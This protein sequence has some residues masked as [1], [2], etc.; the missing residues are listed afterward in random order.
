ME[1]IAAKEIAE[2]TVEILRPFCMRIEIAGSIRRKRS[3][4][5]D[6]E[7]VCI[8]HNRDLVKFCEAVNKWQR[9]KGTPS[10]KNTQRMLPARNLSS[11]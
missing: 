4:C 7:I 11:T 1:Y 10:G 2:K 6:V 8:R 3:L 5:G 9:I